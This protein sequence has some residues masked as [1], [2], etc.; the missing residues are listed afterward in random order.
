MPAKRIMRTSGRLG[1]TVAAAVLLAGGGAGSAVWA[2][3]GNHPTFHAGN[4]GLRLSADPNF[5]LESESDRSII[6]SVCA[7]RNDQRFTFTDNPDA[8][9]VLTDGYGECLDRGAAAPGSLF[10]TAQCSFGA[11]ERF[12]FTLAGKLQEPGGGSCVAAALA[13][14]DAKVYNLPCHGTTYDETFELSQ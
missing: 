3:A 11:S 12:K 14:Q 2:Q 8:T 4:V 10:T 6:V 9:N 7:A 1:V 13:A 5:C